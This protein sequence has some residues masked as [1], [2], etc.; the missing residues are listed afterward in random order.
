MAKAINR[1][2]G[3]KPIDL[4]S[5]K[6]RKR[7]ILENRDNRYRS[8]EGILDENNNRIAGYLGAFGWYW[9]M[10]RGLFVSKFDE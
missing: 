4:K 3:G 9:G 8:E 10:P 5:F 2:Y 7:I 6:C 1:T